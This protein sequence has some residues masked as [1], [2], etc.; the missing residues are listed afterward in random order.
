LAVSPR[1][2]ILQGVYDLI[3]Q[4]RAS[5]RCLAYRVGWGKR[6][7]GNV[8][9][10]IVRYRIFNAPICSLS[11]VCAHTWCEYKS[12]AH[13]LVHPKSQESLWT[14]PTLHVQHRPIQIT[15]M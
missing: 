11:A 13:F 14:C 7:T 9:L 8:R 15:P 2:K 1:F 3:L 6:R 12:T 5:L 4:S 10:V